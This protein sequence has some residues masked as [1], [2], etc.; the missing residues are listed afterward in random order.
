MSWSSAVTG[1]E[2]SRR[3]SPLESSRFGLSFSRIDVPIGVATPEALDLVTSA[4]DEDEADIVVVRHP[5]DRVDWFARLR[6][7]RRDLIAADTLVYWRLLVGNGRSPAEAAGIT[8]DVRRPA[9]ELVDE[10]VTDMFRGYGNHYLANPL[11]DPAAAL[12][13]YVE[14]GRHSVVDGSAVVLD[15][16]G[17]GAV[18]LATIHTSDAVTEIQLAG[19]RQNAQRRGLYPHLLAGC[20]HLARDSRSELLVISTQAHNAGVQRA[21]SRYGFEPVGAVS[22]VHAVRPGLLP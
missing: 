18:G 4:L 3:S 7:G 13:G 22:T 9:P 14:W 5:A 6:R 1:R 11:L 15:R 16:V 10:L 12:A 8:A 20:E 19:I 21:W 2:V 17:T